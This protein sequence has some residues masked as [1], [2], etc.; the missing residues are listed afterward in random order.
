MMNRRTLLR[1][2]LLLC[3]CVSTVDA[4][5]SSAASGYPGWICHIL[6]CA[7]TP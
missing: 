4:T 1:S 2:V 7:V 3:L 5:S 6:N